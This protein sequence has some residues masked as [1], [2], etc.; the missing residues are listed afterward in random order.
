MEIKILS[1]VVPMRILVLCIDSII[2]SE[3]KRNFLVER[4]DEEPSDLVLVD[5]TIC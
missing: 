1:A 4:L 5:F 3:G 2:G